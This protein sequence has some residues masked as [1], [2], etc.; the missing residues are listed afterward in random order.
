MPFVGSKRSTQSFFL[1]AL[2]KLLPEEVVLS[3]E[4]FDFHE[5]AFFLI[6]LARRVGETAFVV[7]T[8]GAEVLKVHGG[9]DSRADVFIV[10]HHISL[11]L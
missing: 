9:V 4:L 1:L 11:L 7:R 6:K 10:F 8:E 2:S 3:F 5:I